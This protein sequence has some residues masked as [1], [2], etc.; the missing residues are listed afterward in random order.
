MIAH[1][2]LGLLLAQVPLLVTQLAAPCAPL[3]PCLPPPV[4]E[5]LM[6]TAALKRP[7]SESAADKRAAVEAVIS[8]LALGSCRWGVLDTVASLGV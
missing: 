4:H 8:K 7:V 5:M 6:Y 2:R 1:A 3:A